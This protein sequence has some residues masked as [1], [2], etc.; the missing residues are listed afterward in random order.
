MNKAKKNFP[1]I[2]LLTVVF[3]SMPFKGV[4]SVN[5]ANN[6]T[7]NEVSTSKDSIK[8][9]LLLSKVDEF[10]SSVDSIGVIN[11]STYKEASGLANNCLSIYNELSS[12]EKVLDNV[13][14]SKTKLD[15]ILA[16]ILEYQHI[17]DFVSTLHMDENEPGQCNDYYGDA[18]SSYLSLTD[19]EKGILQGGEYTEEWSR[20]HAWIIA[21]GE[22]FIHGGIGKNSS[23]HQGLLNAMYGDNFEIIIL[24]LAFVSVV[25]IL[26]TVL[27]VIKKKR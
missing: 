6:I 2:L 25:G 17:E 15:N 18:K 21:N 3:S 23:T 8:P 27:V 7:V 11:K 4:K 16:L 14:S 22:V 5:T 24:L 19:S 26:T 12:E 13:I 9:Y 20:F 1:I 10:I